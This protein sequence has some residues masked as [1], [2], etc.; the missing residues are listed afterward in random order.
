MKKE[1]LSANGEIWSYNPDLVKLTGSYSIPIIK[2]KECDYCR[3]CIPRINL[4]E[5]N[6]F[7]IS[8]SDFGICVENNPKVIMITSRGELKCKKIKKDRKI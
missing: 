8:E 4:G 1:Y 7:G 2:R 3:F 6:V 5:R